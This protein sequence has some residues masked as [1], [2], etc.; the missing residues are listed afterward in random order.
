MVSFLELPVKGAHDFCTCCPPKG[1]CNEY[2]QAAAAARGGV[3]AIARRETDGAEPGA[4]AS[5]G[6][7]GG[8]AVSGGFSLRRTCG[9]VSAPE[10]GLP[11]PV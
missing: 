6:D 10:V 9:G 2:R 8:A 11:S 4:G 7:H 1:R 5:T 3:L